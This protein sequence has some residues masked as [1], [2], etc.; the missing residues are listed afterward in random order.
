MEHPDGRE[1]AKKVNLADVS[2]Q[3]L[4]KHFIP[5]ALL[6]NEKFE[7]VYLQGDT[8]NYFRLPSGEPSKNI[9]D[10][11]RESLRPVLSSG[12]YNAISKK[13]E[14]SFRNVEVKVNGATERVN[15][16]TRPAEHPDLS[17][18]ALAMVVM[19][20]AL[21]TVSG[22]EKE[23]SSSR[24]KGRLRVVEEELAATRERLN[25][26]IEEMQ[27]SGEEMKS[28][29]EELQ[30]ANEELQSTNEEL[31]PPKEL[32]SMNEELS[33]EFRNG[34]QNGRFK[35]GKDFRISWTAQKIG[36]IFMIISSD[37]TLHRIR[38]R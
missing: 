1:A 16:F 36:I 30:S 23:K 31:N 24:E 20:S 32:Q 13:K 29:N 37:K 7:I 34:G 22:P 19:E 27:A 10:S 18:M 8:G 21:K 14:S 33:P 26:I 9:L 28:T 17:G 4:L 15:V 3:I 5:L 2:Q 35:G 6:V 25:T 38:A 11:A 12:I